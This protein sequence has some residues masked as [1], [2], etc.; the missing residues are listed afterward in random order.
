MPSSIH[1]LTCSVASAMSGLRAAAKRL[2]RLSRSDMHC[3]RL[4]ERPRLWDSGVITTLRVL[5][6]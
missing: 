2:G 1:S 3:V 4:A 6:I 5:G